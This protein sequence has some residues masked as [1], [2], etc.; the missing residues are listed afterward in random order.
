M[1]KLIQLDGGDGGGQILRTALSLAIITGQPFRMTN[2]RGQRPR[3]GLM[4]QHLTCVKAACEISD[5][6]ADGAE[7]SSTELVFRAGK[8]RGGSYQFSIG[9]AGSTSLLFQ[10]LLP[11]LW[12]AGKPSSLRL[13]GGTHN[14]MAPPFEFLE[15]VFLPL[16]K[17]QGVQASLT[18]EQTGFAPAGGGCI[19]AA[20]HPCENLLQLDHQDRGEPL[21]R[22]LIAVT[23]GLSAD[24][25]ER[26][27]Q[28]ARDVLEWSEGE[29]EVR[30]PGPGRGLC[31][32]VEQKFEHAVELCSAFGEQGITAERVGHRAAKMMKVFQGTGAA[33]GR[34]LADQLLLP[35]AMAGRG[36]FTTVALDRHVPTNI[37]VIEKFLPVRFVIS[38]LDR[39]RKR[40]ECGSA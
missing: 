33:A 22:H 27:I 3:P 16:L 11:A 28:A 31:V 7:I 32:L 40:V 37:S 17:R 19:T 21:E 10:T 30:E 4:R 25:S 8:V 12:T 2:I 13:E 38:D 29:R 36:S 24:I 14:P 6:T 26:A 9:T 15:R 23:R 34:H 35:M 18:L 1:S 39:G 5:G 20:I